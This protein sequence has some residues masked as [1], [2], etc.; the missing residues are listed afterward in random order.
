MEMHKVV[1]FHRCIVDFYYGYWELKW[2]LD[3]YGPQDPS[4]VNVSKLKIWRSQVQVPPM[5]NF[6]IMI[7][8]LVK[9]TRGVE[10]H[11]I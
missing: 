4:R 2:A 11:Q 1:T 7:K 8:L 10:P 3:P 9:S 6:S 5:T